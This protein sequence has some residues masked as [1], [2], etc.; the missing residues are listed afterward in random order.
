MGT[1][2]TAAP[3]L[4]PQSRAY[5]ERKAELQEAWR[6]RIFERDEFQ[7]QVCEEKGTPETLHLA[8]VT[9]ALAFV[10]ATGRL[11]GM[12]LS[13]REDNLLTVCPG[14]HKVQH[15]EIDRL[16]NPRLG[17]LLDEQ[18]SLRS[19][20]LIKQWLD[21]VKR[22]G[23]EIEVART[24]ARRRKRVAD[25][26]FRSIKKERGWS[27]ALELTEAQRGIPTWQELGYTPSEKCYGPSGSAKKR[28]RVAAGSC[29]YSA[30]TC[31]GE[32]SP[33]RDCGLPYCDYHYP[34]H[35]TGR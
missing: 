9:T 17:E 33:C 11:D 25:R 30:S 21:L 5:R 28:T 18:D 31:T 23:E 34:T 27:S 15:K 20:P 8:H 32:I 14:C 35:R 22:I 2:L 26:L 4:S 19:E 1:V 7:C 13:Y 29:T 12:D 3:G 6:E 16:W 10:K 24:E